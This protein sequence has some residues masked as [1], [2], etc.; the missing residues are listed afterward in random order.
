[1]GQQ[2]KAELRDFQFPYTNRGGGHTLENGLRACI[3]WLEV[4]FF[5]VSPEQLISDILLLNP[6]T[7]FLDRGTN[8]YRQC[9]RNSSIA[10][11]FDGREDMGIHLEMTGRGCREYESYNKRSWKQLCTVVLDYQASFSR[12]D[13]AVDDFEGFFTIKGIVRKVKNKELVSKFKRARNFEDIEITTGKVGGITVYFGSNK[14]N[15]QIRMYDK[16]SERQNT[17]YMLPDG[18]SFWNRTEI[19]L[20]NTKAQLVAEILATEKEGEI[21]I[22]KTVCGIL[23]NYLRFTV[24]G[25]DSNRSRWKTAPFWR[26]FLAGV[27][28]LPLTI[29]KETKTIEDKEEWLRKQAAPSLAVIF[30]AYGGDIDKIEEIIIEGTQRLTPKDYDMIN[31]YKEN[32]KTPIVANNE[33]LQGFPI[34]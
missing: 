22:G 32:K 17:N 16:L 14:S 15:V 3:D 29:I 1:M 26:N 31:Q 4:T 34:S 7:F 6:A 18:I 23:K 25:K 19:Q 8:G 2:N 13:I 28:V 27:D 11:F 9:L 5:S 10:I 24:K 12:L 30:E 20:R 33:S 21:A